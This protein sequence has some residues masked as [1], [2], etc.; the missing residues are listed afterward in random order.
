MSDPLQD[1]R[2]F[3]SHAAQGNKGIVE[4]PASNAVYG[5]SVA[6]FDKWA[7]S[8]AVRANGF[9]FIAGAVGIRADGTVPDSVQEQSD[10]AF[11]RLEEI[12][13]LEG[14]A[15]TDLVEVVSYHVGLKAN[16]D[17]FMPVKARHFVRPFPAWTLIGVE[18]LGSSE[19]K[20]EIR[21]TAVYPVTAG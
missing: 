17:A 14:L 8:A 10:F 11:K 20:V 9:L 13:R 16:L 19:L 15:M 6:G 18:A 5:Q 2:T 1:R 12:L 4:I 3:P 7:Y 21:A